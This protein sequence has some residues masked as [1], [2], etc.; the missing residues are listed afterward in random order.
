MDLPEATEAAVSAAASAAWDHLL[1]QAEVGFPDACHAMGFPAWAGFSAEEEVQRSDTFARGVVAELLVDCGRLDAPRQ[2]AARSLARREAHHL[3]EAAARRPDGGLAYFPG[4][5]EL[6]P[7]ADSLASALV[8]SAEA[9]PELAPRWARWLELA[10]AP[11]LEG[12]PPR[13]WL[14]DPDAP[15]RAREAMLRG[16]R[17]HWGE[18]LDVGVAARLLRALLIVDRGRFEGAVS[19]ATAA[20]LRDRAPEDPFDATWYW[21]QAHPTALVADLLLELDPRHAALPGIGRALGG[22][23]RADDRGWG[24]WRAAGLPTAHALA[25]LARIEGDSPALRQ[26]LACLL[27]LQRRDGGWG[28]SPWIMM[29]RGRAAGSPAGAT[30]FASTSVSTAHAL[31]ALLLCRAQLWEAR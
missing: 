30:T 3:A 14:V 20:L 27:D 5:P 4:L 8:L 26:G 25:A 10:A 15:P 16:I 9:A 7:D 18:G 2:E 12:A 1:A 23:Q 24:R 31:R 11:I 17:L 6:P 13:T 28:E 21:G 22:L 19:A 29:E